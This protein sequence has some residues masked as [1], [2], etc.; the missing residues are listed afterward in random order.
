MKNR[1]RDFIKFW[2][3]SSQ[4]LK[5]AQKVSFYKIT[6]GASYLY[7]QIE[8]QVIFDAK[9]QIFEYY[10]QTLWLDSDVICIFFFGGTK[11]TKKFFYDVYI[12]VIIA[13]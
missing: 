10:F 6:N 4:C 2:H 1:C 3:S 13:F 8:V 9:F 12:V 11:C 5:I 7:F